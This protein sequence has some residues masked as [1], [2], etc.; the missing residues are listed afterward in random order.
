MEIL[1]PTL[2][3]VQQQLL[4]SQ[5]GRQRTNIHLLHLR[6]QP[7]FRT[8]P[9]NISQTRLFQSQGLKRSFPR[10][11]AQNINKNGRRWKSDDAKLDSTPDSQLSIG[12]RLKKLSREYGWAAVYVYFGLSLLDFPFCFLA[13]TL[14]GA[15][16]VGHYE[17]IVV[18]WAK[19]VLQWPLGA[20]AA[21]HV[22]EAVDKVAEASG[23]EDGQRVLEEDYH[24]YK[25][26]E[27]ANSGSN[28]SRWYAIH[29]N[30]R[31]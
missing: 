17:H 14:I 1:R 7:T 5:S 9:G 11:R 25:E 10:L 4:R 3:N 13:V 18:E 15:D 21:Q 31:C 27:K 12:Q 28:A 8:R 6:T 30:I 16:R 26:A 20:T 2:R 23:A 29:F 19:G 22:G 24:G